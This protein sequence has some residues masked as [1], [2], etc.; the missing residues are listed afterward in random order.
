LSLFLLSFVSL[1]CNNFY[2]I[3]HEFA[4]HIPCYKFI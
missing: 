2:F 3:F 1:F 4:L